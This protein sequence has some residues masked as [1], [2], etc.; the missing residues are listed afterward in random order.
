[1]Y[2]RCGG[3]SLCKCCKMATNKWRRTR[4]L[5]VRQ[6]KQQ[7]AFAIRMTATKSNAWNVEF[8]TNIFVC[9][10][11][12]INQNNNSNSSI[13][14]RIAGWLIELSR[15]YGLQINQQQRQQ[16]QHFMVK[17]IYEVLHLILGCF[18]L[19]RGPS[20]KFHIYSVWRIKQIIV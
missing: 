18:A 8:K 4:L 16:Q 5:F 3:S 10:N 17:N 6:Q 19:L 2:M 15:M 1:M 20:I 14:P 12:R 7:K 11:S 9:S 13:E